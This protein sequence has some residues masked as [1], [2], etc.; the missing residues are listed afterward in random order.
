MVLV[1][2]PWSVLYLLFW[3]RPTVTIHR[4]L[5]LRMLKEVT[6]TTRRRMKKWKQTIKLERQPVGA[7][8]EPWP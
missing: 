7:W 1:Q 4:T 5:R 6:Q 2:D 3:L 8:N